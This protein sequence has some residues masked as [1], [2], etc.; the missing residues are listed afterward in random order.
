M[1]EKDLYIHAPSL[2]DLPKEDIAVEIS[3]LTKDYGKGK[4]LFD[5]SFKVPRGKTFGYCGTNGAG[6]TTTLRHI[7][8]F[9]K[10]D[11]G[12]VQV[13]GLDAWNDA[14]QIKKFI[15]YLPG[16][17]AFPP[18]E[19]GSEFLKSQAEML[20]VN[21]MAKAEKIINALQL[22]PTA[23]LKRMSKGMKQ[24]TALV[25]AFM[26]SPEIILL[27]EPTTGL[28]PL[29]RD[30]FIRLI[31]E[32]LL[33]L[34][35]TFGDIANLLDSLYYFMEVSDELEKL[36]EKNNL[37]E[38]AANVENYVFKNIKNQIFFNSLAQLKSRMEYLK[39]Q[40]NLNKIFP[41]K[42]FPNLDLISDTNS[43]GILNLPGQEKLTIH[44]PDF[45]KKIN[46]KISFNKS[47]FSMNSSKGKKKVIKKENPNED[48]ELN[49]LFS[50][51]L[52]CNQFQI[53]QANL[54]NATN[55]NEEMNKEVKPNLEFS[56]LFSLN[57]SSKEKKK[58]DNKQDKSNMLTI[59]DV[60]QN[61][62][63]ISI[64]RLPNEE[65]IDSEDYD[66][67]LIEPEQMSEY[68]SMILNGTEVDN[69]DIRNRIEWFKKISE[70]G[71]YLAY[72]WE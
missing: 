61:K 11:A 4:G 47:F 44:T 39:N 21:D 33:K 70:Q 34:S 1:E 50:G 41:L 56:H 63:N 72:D 18:F 10:P 14:P 29:M 7:M 2:L 16:E 32:S 59:L 35:Q 15:G 51:Q 49:E 31:K 69:I 12:S 5:I 25:A 54:N 48:K 55:Q 45:N 64:P 6:K 43:P 30:A 37:P 65:W 46:P 3:H 40:N 68:C 67:E 23:N 17:I 60:L 22:D 8:G 57:E 66:L 26:H 71:Y 58:E 20:G 53:N 19:N 27:D 52:K 36:C 62:F 28:D 9:I 38:G 42:D 13:F 24:K